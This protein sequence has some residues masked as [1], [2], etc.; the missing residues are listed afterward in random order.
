MMIVTPSDWKTQKKLLEHTPKDL[1]HLVGWFGSTHAQALWRKH[2]AFLAVFKREQTPGFDPQVGVGEW[3]PAYANIEAEVLASASVLIIRLENNELANGSLG[4]IAEIGMA[5]TSAALRGQIVVISVEEGLLTSLDEPGAIAQYLMLETFLDQWGAV[6]QVDNLLRIHRGE[7]LSLLA[8]MACEAAQQQLT[9][10]QKPLDFE[11]FLQKKARRRQNYPLR[12]VV[13]GSGGP[14][15][16]EQN[17]LFQQKKQSLVGPYRAEGYLVKELSAGTIAEAWEISYSSPDPVQVASATRTLLR[18]EDEYKRE[19]D[20]LLLPILAEAASKAA[21]TEIGLLLLNALATGQ[22]IRIF[23]EPFNPV[24][25][26]RSQF[27]I[28]DPKACKTE[29]ESRLALQAA[30]VEDHILA[31]ATRSEIKKACG[32]IAA[33]YRNDPAPRFKQIKSSLLGKTAA[34]Q[35]ADNIRRVRT[36]VQAHLETLHQDKRF[37]DFFAYSTQI[38]I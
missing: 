8:Q 17:E 13:A 2:Q 26:L 29:K 1:L 14:Y 27:Q 36:L 6:P 32:L 18:L 4:S 5:L 15:D 23:F 35:H 12:V 20:I 34:F 28:I 30:G 25:Y 24:Q 7:D 10:G 16:A 19:A 38:E 31:A 3:R 21:A 37:S 11:D 33:L 9:A 22:S